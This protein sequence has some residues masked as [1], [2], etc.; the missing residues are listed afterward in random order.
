MAPRPLDERIDKPES[1]IDHALAAAAWASGRRSC[2]NY[3]GD[4]TSRNGQALVVQ[5]DAAMATAHATTALAL[6]R[7]I[8]RETSP[9]QDGGTEFEPF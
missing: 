4:P 3:A 1:A 9:L 6:E 2:T 5:A 7:I 8:G